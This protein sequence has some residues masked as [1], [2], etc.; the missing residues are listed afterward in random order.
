MLTTGQGSENS[1][2]RNLQQINFPFLSHRTSTVGDLNIPFEACTGRQ[3]VQSISGVW[4]QN[5]VSD[6]SSKLQ[7]AL[8]GLWLCRCPFGTFEWKQPELVKSLVPPLLATVERMQE[9]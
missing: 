9:R 1:T 3:L 7:R 6:A 4:L 8:R 2:V 5:A